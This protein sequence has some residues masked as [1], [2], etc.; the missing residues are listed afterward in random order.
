M[1]Q[2]RRKWSRGLSVV[3]DESTAGGQITVLADH[4]RRGR[5]LIPPL[6]TQ[7]N[8]EESR[9]LYR[10]PDL[11]WCAALA[12]QFGWEEGVSLSERLVAAIQGLQDLD[13]K[14][15][16]LSL[17]ELSYL[18]A[19]HWE[20]IRASLTQLGLLAKY[21]EA[22]SR[23]VALYPECPL[24]PLFVDGAPSAPADA[25]E[26]VKRLIGTLIDG[27][28]TQATMLL[29]TTG[30]LAFQ[31]GKLKLVKGVELGDLNAVLQYP[32]TEESRKV[33][34]TIRAMSSLL[35]GFEP[36]GGV[37]SRWCR[38][39]WNRGLELESCD[40]RSARMRGAT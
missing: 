31:T 15:F 28:G 34:A 22:F 18:T 39:F 10:L 36:D 26:R 17:T 35:A 2:S 24:R 37:P 13:S 19:D 38:H 40:L 1:S 5:R 23:L 27:R 16:Y 33:A 20:A 30:Y 8:I 11:I 21:Q 29:T 12:D 6:A 4:V 25:R 3:A 14:H 7:L 9:W 32:D